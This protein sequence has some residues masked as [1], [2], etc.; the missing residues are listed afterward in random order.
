[1]TVASASKACGIGI[2]PMHRGMTSAV[3]K[4][5]SRSPIP[6]CFLREITSFLYLPVF[7]AERMGKMPMPL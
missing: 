2:L 3:A 4:T 5:P 7:P 6:S 1:M